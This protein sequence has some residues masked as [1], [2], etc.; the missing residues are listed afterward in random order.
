MHINNPPL[1]REQ[2]KALRMDFVFKLCLIC[3]SISI[4][5]PL[6]NNK[7]TFLAVEESS[8]ASNGLSWWGDSSWRTGQH[9]LHIFKY[10]AGT[11]SP[12][13]RNLT[14]F[15]WN[16]LYGYCSN[17]LSVWTQWLFPKKNLWYKCNA[18]K[19]IALHKI[20]FYDNIIRKISRFS[21][22][23]FRDRAHVEGEVA[24]FWE[25]SKRGGDNGQFY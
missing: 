10:N 25:R 8:R 3:P 7:T 20:L 17:C 21:F 6:I 15:N 5:T 13:R 19:N 14:K 16:I 24:R 23:R 11:Q 4:W 18:I 22:E 9:F 12:L 1:L 2:Q